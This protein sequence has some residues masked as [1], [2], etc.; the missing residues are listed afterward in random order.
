MKQPTKQQT[1]SYTRKPTERAPLPNRLVRLLSEARWFALVALALYFL[2][3]MASARIPG[4]PA[5]RA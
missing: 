3:I 2:L 4:V 1:L 5:R